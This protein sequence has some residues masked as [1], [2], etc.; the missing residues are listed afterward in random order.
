MHVSDCFT[1]TNLMLVWGSEF[2]LTITKAHR[3]QSIVFEVWDKDV[4]K[5]DFMGVV[6]LPISKITKGLSCII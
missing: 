6:T 1:K 3:N 2:L 5:K 4:V